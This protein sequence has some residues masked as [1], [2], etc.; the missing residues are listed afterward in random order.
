MSLTGI[1]ATL[2]LFDQQDITNA[3]YNVNMTPVMADWPD[4]RHIPLAR[5]CEIIVPISVE[6]TTALRT[7]P[8]TKHSSPC[9]L[10]KTG[11]G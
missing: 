6:K 8:L 2:C 11:G 4:P 7:A 9:P 10:S 5:I 3:K 1:S